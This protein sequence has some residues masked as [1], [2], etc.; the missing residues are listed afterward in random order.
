[1]ILFKSYYFKEMY[2]PGWLGVFVNPFYFS[3]LGLYR[4]MTEF[5]PKLRGVLLDV[6][7]GTKPYKQLFNV[8]AYIGLE[9][10]SVFSRQRDIADY[11][12]DGKKFPFD[13][14]SFDSVLCNQVL[15][16]V[17]NP[18]EFLEQLNRVLKPNGSLLLT[19]P[20]VWDEHEQPYDFA[21]YSSFGLRALLEKHGFRIIEHRKT[22]ADASVLF[23]LTNAFIFKIIQSFPKI[24]KL[25]LTV[26]VMATINLCGIFF[27]R[28]LP[29][30]ADLFLDNI[31]LAEKIS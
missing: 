17:F 18:D 2:T 29:V 23:Q 20:F 10:D 12:Y 4:A 26:S 5:A 3:R 6:G 24:C 13:D 7:C 25:L 1:V 31:V 28:V 16:H 27:S 15:E 9:I 19:V 21:R 30:N 8:S 11:F 22:C 14:A